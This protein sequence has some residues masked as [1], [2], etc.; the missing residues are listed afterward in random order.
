MKIYRVD[1]LVIG[2][3]LAGL[4]YA[5]QASAKGLKVLVLA[6]GKTSTSS[7]SWMAQGGIVYDGPGEVELFLNDLKM[8]TANSYY[9]EAAKSIFEES[10]AAID[11]LLIDRAQVPFDR[12]AQG[13]LLLVKEAA[14]SKERIIF[15]KD[16][17]GHAIME[18]V[19]ALVHKQKNIEILEQ[20][21]AIDLMTLSHNSTNADHRYLPL[22]VIGCYAFDLDTKEVVGIISKNTILATGGIGQLFYHTT[23]GP[24]A[25][26]D[27]LAMAY[28][29]GTRLMDLEYVQFHPTVFLSPGFQPLLISEALRGEGAH[30]VNHKGE[31]FMNK[32]HPLGSLAP[33]DTVARSIA[34]EMHRAGTNSAFLDARHL[35]EEFLRTRFPNIFA[36]CLERGINPGK[37]LIPVV[38]AAHYLCGGIHTDLKGRTNIVGLRAVGECA[39]TGLHGANRLASTSLMECV[40]MGRRA[41]NEDV[42]DSHT[43]KNDWEVNAWISEKNKVDETL[44]QQDLELIKKTLWNY[45]GLIRTTA[46]LDRA[47]KIINELIYE[48]RQFYAQTELSEDLLHLRNAVE[49][50]R[51]IIHAASRNKK[52]LGCHYLDN[53]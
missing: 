21:V 20:H 45:V 12:D 36:A 44:V 1:S 42:I 18:S 28:R 41:A 9:P 4:S 6:G 23:N 27:G 8:A 35:G 30:L 13:K 2:P 11:D 39:C 50:A 52:S 26:G 49:V 24:K 3:G 43:R 10:R 31:R 7:N 40:T 19:H 51:L 47:E 16:C 38:P 48:V 53:K 32:I 46:R 14:H 17:T 37:D 29:V 15:A 34:L 22:T 25:F 33:R 5:L